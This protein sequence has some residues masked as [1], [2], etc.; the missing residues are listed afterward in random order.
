MRIY[1]VIVPDD[2]G[3]FIAQGLV[4]ADRAADLMPEFRALTMS[5]R[6]TP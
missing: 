2:T 6:L 4:R 5:F 3:Y 1:Q